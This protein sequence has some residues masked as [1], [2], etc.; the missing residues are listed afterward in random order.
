MFKKIRY[1]C[2][3]KLNVICFKVSY[4]FLLSPQNH[5]SLINRK[6]QCSSQEREK[7]HLLNYI[8]LSLSGQNYCSILYISNDIF[9]YERLGALGKNLID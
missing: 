1:V 4:T 9:S 2:I 3:F 6:I 8:F 5:F 7:N